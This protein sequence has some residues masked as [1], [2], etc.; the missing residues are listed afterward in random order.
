VSRVSIRTKLVFGVGLLFFAAGFLLL[1][2]LLAPSPLQLAFVRYTNNGAVLSLTNRSDSAVPV[3]CAHPEVFF[4]GL[5]SYFP[6]TRPGK[7]LLAEHCSTQVVAWP[8]PRLITIALTN[9]IGR[10]PS[11]LPQLP[12][13]LS[14]QYFPSR[15]ALRRRLQVL[16]EPIGITIANTGVVASAELPMRVTTK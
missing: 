13:S 2:T 11:P 6:E 8:A 10:P 3:I 5:S 9:A 14:V 1:R 15:S 4:T 7:L 12:S 16:L